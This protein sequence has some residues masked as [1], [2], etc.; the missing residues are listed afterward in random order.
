MVTAQVGG[1]L[2]AGMT[3]YAKW[4]KPSLIVVGAEPAAVDDAARSKA[5]GK[6]LDHGGAD[7]DT[8]ADGLK[9]LLGTH[10]WPVVRD[11]VDRVITV[12]EDSIKAATKLVWGRMK[13]CVEPSAGVGVACVLGDAFKAAYPA[14]KYT[15]VGV[16]LCGGN[17]DLA[18]AAKVLF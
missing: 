17:L 10:T 15:T 13:L 6:L 7:P 11:L 12:D 16:V 18:K 9:T 4:R 2:I 14:E 5:A 1:G 8:V 3:V